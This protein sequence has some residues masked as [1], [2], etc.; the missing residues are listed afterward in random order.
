VLLVMERDANQG[1]AARVKRVYR[2]DLRDVGDDGFLAKRLVCDLLDIADPDGVTTAE[3]GA[4]GLG[5]RFAMPF[6][7]PEALAIL[8]ARTL[9][10]ANDNNYPFSAGRRA[11]A[12]DDNEVVRVRVD[13]L[14]Q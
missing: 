10:V 7:T 12:P 4:V 5:A 8:D 6:V 2:V 3:D 11:G 1:E 13:D 14:G 9:L